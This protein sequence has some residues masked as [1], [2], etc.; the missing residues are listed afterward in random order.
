MS[1]E[2]DE[3]QKSIHTYSKENAKSQ[4]NPIAQLLLRGVIADSKA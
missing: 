4:A 3:G 2:L 1:E